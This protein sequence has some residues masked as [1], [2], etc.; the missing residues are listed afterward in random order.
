MLYPV[1]LRA[2]NLILTYE[3][4]GKCI[5]VRAVPCHGYS[6]AKSITSLDAFTALAG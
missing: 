6:E 3:T 1:E 5:H 2:Q 4:L